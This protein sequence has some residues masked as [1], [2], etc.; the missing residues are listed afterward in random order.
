MASPLARSWEKSRDFVVFGAL[1]LVSVTV[2]LARDGPALRAA[3]GG[4]LA[5]TAPVEAAFAGLTRYTDA[6][7]E[8]GRLRREAATLAAEVA[9][10]RESRAESERLRELVGFGDSLGVSRVAARVVGKDITRQTNFLTIDAGSRDSV[11]VGMPVVDERG[12]IGRVVL[13]SANYAVVMPHQNTQ[14]AVPATIDLLDQDGIVRWDGTAYDRLLMEFVPKTEPVVPG[15]LVV[16]SPYSGVF[17]PGI[18]V[19]IVDTAY[20]ARGRNDYVI[21]LRPAAP[22]TQARYVY[23]LRIRPSAER[24]ALEA[25]ARAA[26][27]VPVPGAP[28][29]PPEEEPPP[30]PA[31]E[32]DGAPEPPAPDAPEPADGE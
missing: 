23:V 31:P 25:R 5:A 18:P 6:L 11:E 4:A 28:A 15:Q 10:L 21:Y 22:I 29:E 1:L 30:A 2:L 32:G 12:V 8:N 19:G 27:G 3:R 20:A 7:G 9:R 26:E 17:P 13:V 14:F 24:E 16:T